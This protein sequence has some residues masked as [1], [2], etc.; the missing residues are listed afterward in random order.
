MAL[1]GPQLFT[2]QAA[3]APTSAPTPTPSFSA[4]FAPLLFGVVLNAM[5]FGVFVV[6]VHSYFR[7]YKKDYPWIRYLIFYL[8]VMEIVNTICDVGL[9]YEPLITLH[10]SP[11]A[12]VK[13]P[14]LLAA[15]PIITVLIS[16]PTQ[17][18]MAWR[19]RLVTKSKWLALVVAVLAFTSLAGGIAA[20]IGVSLVRK[21]A[22][23]SHV[24][25]AITTWLTSTAFADVAVTAFLVNFLVRSTRVYVHVYM[26]TGAQW[27]NKTGFKTQTDSVAD[28][29]IF[30]TI[31]T[32][33]LTSFA[34]IADATLFLVVPNTTLM[35]IWDF[36]L[37][38][39][40]SISLI[41]TLN[42]RAEWN[43]LLTDTAGDDEKQ[44]NPN[45]IIRI[46][47]ATDIQGLQLYIP[48]Q[49]EMNNGP[50]PRRRT[51]RAEWIPYPLPLPAVPRH[52]HTSKSSVSS[53]RTAEWA[54]KTGR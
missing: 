25:A 41:S 48:G 23:F 42:A 10:D 30:M 19:I 14:T 39:L 13:S 49:F 16:T 11:V 50:S 22:L 40:Y 54:M 43:N 6:Q 51:P 26:L 4:M 12:L 45:A 20:T 9:I 35:F 32:G 5:L 47:S 1:A 36:S 15:D 44:P 7:L 24:E 18:F 28:K 21:F 2:P 8:I 3:G 46:Q 52:G 27:M 38:K 37:S 31:Q 53:A 33:A 29:I 34:A 17:L